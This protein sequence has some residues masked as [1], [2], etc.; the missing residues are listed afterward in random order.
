M[1]HSTIEINI[2]NI[3]TK[4][5]QKDNLIEDNNKQSYDMNYCERRS[6]VAS[7]GTQE[8]IKSILDSFVR[9]DVQ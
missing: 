4:K 5:H 7:A 3:G 2:A 8:P 1:R 9:S 6:T